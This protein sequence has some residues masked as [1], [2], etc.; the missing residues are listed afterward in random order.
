ML[1]LTNNP[2]IVLYIILHKEANFLDQA[3]FEIEMRKLS[4]KVVRVGIEEIV[5]KI[6]LKENKDLY[7]GE[8]R[9]A[10]VYYRSCYRIDQLRFGEGYNIDLSW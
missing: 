3:R 5:G 4:L 2:G 10:L 9:V 7:Y 8:E 1:K 6:S